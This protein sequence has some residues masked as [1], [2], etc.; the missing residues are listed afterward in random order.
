M[1]T[2]NTK[3]KLKSG[4]TVFGCFVRYNDPALVDFFSYL[5]WDFIVIDAE[6]GSIEPRDCENMVRAMELHD[7]TPIIRV[8]TNQ[9]HIILRFLD[10]GA[11]GLHIPWVNSPEEAENAVRWVKYQPRGIR[12]LGSVRAAD[13][14]Q[15]GPLSEY[16]KRANAE[17]LVVLHVETKE[18]IEELPKTAAIDGVDVIFIGPTDLS[19]SLGVPGNPQHP[20][21]AKAIDRIA[22]IVRGTNVALG[23]MAGNAEAAR[24][25]RD[26]G[27]QYLTTTFEAVVRQGTRDY[28][29]QARGVASRAPTP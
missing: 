2:N 18:A 27:F 24:R 5:D 17:T 23:I 20:S 9:P 7:V 8:T 1:R 19:Q 12:G 14:G 11:Q 15:K 13:Y 22:G 6:H 3:A 4:A 29:S 25:W 16:V 26:A 21:V 10:T 28:L